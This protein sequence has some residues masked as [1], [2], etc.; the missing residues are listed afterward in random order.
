MVAACMCI[1]HFNTI[2]FSFKSAFESF[3]HLFH[4]FSVSYVLHCAGDLQTKRNSAVL[5][6]YIICPLSS[7]LSRLRVKSQPLA[8]A[9]LFERRRRGGGGILAHWAQ[10]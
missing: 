4:S 8:A 5:R 7:N 9:T 10:C 3:V 6:M 1:Y 2:H